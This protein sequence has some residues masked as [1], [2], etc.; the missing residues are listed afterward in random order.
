[1]SAVGR[2][3]RLDLSYD[4]TEF[5][6]WQFQPNQRTVQGVVEQSLTELVGGVKTTLRGAGRTDSG[7]HAR[8]QVADAWVETRLDDS[9][10]TRALQH[11]LPPDVRALRLSTVADGFHSRKQALRKLYIYQVDI[12]AAGDPLRRRDTLHH[13]HRCELA[14]LRQALELIPGRRDWSCFTSS[15]CEKVGRVRD[16]DLA[17]LHQPQPHLLQLAFSADGFLQHM[18][19]N[20]VGTL[21]DIAGRR[22]PIELIDTLY[23]NGDRDLAGPTAPALGLT[24][25]R[26]RYAEADDW[27]P[28]L[29]PH[30]D[31]VV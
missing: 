14:P 19:R 26:V 3:V 25:Q 2:R 21:L 27:E 18:V 1:V 12:S 10:L 30:R 29:V 9:Q 8:Q 22:S 4:G 11:L 28:R 24:L 20:I 31:S 7:V 15:S 17:Q 5:A 23:R 16:V 13:P 6:G